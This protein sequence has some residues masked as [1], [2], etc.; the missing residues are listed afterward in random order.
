MTATAPATRRINRGRSHSYV[1][2]GVDVPS[3]TKVLGKAWPKPAL[4]DWAAKETAKY[5]VNNWDDLAAQQIGD[6]LDVLIK[7]RHKTS[8]EAKLRGTTIHDYAHRLAL[9]EEIEVPDEYRDHVDAY[10]AFAEEWQP[11]ELMLERPV[12]SRR[13]R[14]AGTPDLVAV[15][16]D[17]QTWILDWKTGAKGGVFIEHVLQL[18]AARYADFALTDDGTE[19]PVP[20]IDAAG[21]VTLTAS[22]YQLFPVEANADAFRVFRML[23]YIATEMVDQPD[24]WIG[25]PLS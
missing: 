17:G 13:Y 18:A 6:R 14:Y 19:V 24:S 15:L 25:N 20:K 16:R 3:I 12:F 21:I 7:A 9:G 23:R 1:L 5:A 11:A 8:T 2:D 4:I 22:G 10:L